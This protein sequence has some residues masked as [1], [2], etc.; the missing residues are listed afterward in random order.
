MVSRNRPDKANQAMRYRAHNTA[1]ARNQVGAGGSENGGAR[2]YPAAALLAR[3]GRYADATRLLGQ[4]RDAG[5]CSETEALDL[6]ARIYAQQGLYLYAESCWRKAQSL[7]R[8]NPAYAEA[9]DRLR[10]ARQPMGRFFQ[11]L[12]LFGGLA[13]LLLLLWQ[14]VFVNPGISHRQDAAHQS[15]T[16]IR[17]DVGALDDGLKSRDQGLV[18]TLSGIRESMRDFDTRLSERLAAMPSVSGMTENR[19][20]IIG[21]LDNK[22]AVLEKA[23]AQRAEKVKEQQTATDVAHVK[24]FKLIETAVSRLGQTTSGIESDLHDL[25]AQLS[26]RLGAMLTMSGMTENR[27]AIIGYLDDKVTALEKAMARRAGK[28]DER[29]TA[30]DAAHVERLERI[31]AAVSRLG[32][33]ASNSES[34]LAKQVHAVESGIRQD[35]KSLAMSE[36]VSV[37]R[38][39]V[40]ELAK[41]LGLLMAAI[42]ELKQSSS[43]DEAG[44][45]SSRTQPTTQPASQNTAPSADSPPASRSR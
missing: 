32:Q 19:N 4:A 34:S 43:R 9:L 30:A 5:E 31:E 1:Q 2:L 10:R 40:S 29:Q 25:D 16:A 6:Q 12:A 20:A 7:D 27:N 22:V 41:Q 18:M 24:R 13:V 14:I 23:M 42:Q 37:L 26:E 11:V 39:S 33:I 3:K 38:R 17:S 35:M 21:H 45:E 15:L 28:V 44:S 36:E 8:S